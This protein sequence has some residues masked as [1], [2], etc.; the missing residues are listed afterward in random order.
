[1]Q[2]NSTLARVTEPSLEWRA[3]APSAAFASVVRRRLNRIRPWIAAT[4]RTD[5]PTELEAIFDQLIVHLQI[6][7]VFLGGADRSASVA[8]RRVNLQAFIDRGDFSAAALSRLDPATWSSIAHRCP[9]G[10]LQAF[11]RDLSP[12]DIEKAARSA[13][14]ALG[15]PKRGR[16]EQSDSLALRQFALF[17]GR[18]H[19]SATGKVPTRTVKE[20]DRAV[21]DVNFLELGKFKEFVLKFWLLLPPRLRRQRVNSSERI[22]HLVRLAIDEFHQSEKDATAIDAEGK[23]IVTNPTRLWNIDETLWLGKPPGN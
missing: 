5:D 15:K 20:V 4:W 19:L 10:R 21:Y 14:N 23:R 22:D 17:L 2:G 3:R 9:G 6:C 11:Q 12:S 8:Q 16:S 1:M 7:W 13:Q 18:S